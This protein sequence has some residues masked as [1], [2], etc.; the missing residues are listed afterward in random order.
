[1]RQESLVKI[2][3]AVLILVS[4]GAVIGVASYLILNKSKIYPPVKEKVTITTDKTEYTRQDKIKIKIENKFRKNI[5]FSSCSPFSLQEKKEKEWES[6]PHEE[7]K[8]ENR[9]ENCFKSGLKAFE[10]DLSL[11][12]QGLNRIAIPVC[13]D[14]KEGDEFKEGKRFYSNE[15]TIKGK[16]AVDPRCSQ[17]VKGI[18]RC[19]RDSFA[20]QVSLSNGKC[21][22]VEYVGCS[23]EGGF[24]TMEECQKVC[25]KK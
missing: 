7:C 25:E 1:M 17:I 19:I 20:Y 14:C 5:C 15:F 6:Y 22:K 4:V 3:L 18:D 11:T 23:F 13:I 10:I 9:A 24:S 21:E 2:I 12:K 8:D 16:T